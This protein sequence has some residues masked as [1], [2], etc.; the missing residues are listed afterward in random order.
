MNRIGVIA[1]NTNWKYIS[2]D[3]GNLKLGINPFSNGMLACPCSAAWPRTDRGSPRKVWT[4]G[5]P[6]PILNAHSTHV[7]SVRQNVVNTI[8]TVFIAHFF[9]TRPPYSTARA[10]M[11]ISPTSVA[12]VSCQELSPAFSQLG[13]GFTTPPWGNWA[14][15]GPTSAGYTPAAPY[16]CKACVPCASFGSVARL[17]RGR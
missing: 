1:A 16:S 5:V 10:G 9:W 6:K 2:E 8:I 7:M 14:F 17:L 13:Y 4:R 15:R 11:D 3:S 12:A